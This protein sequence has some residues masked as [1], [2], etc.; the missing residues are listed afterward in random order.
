MPSPAP[1]VPPGFVGELYDY[2]R[3]GVEWLLRLHDNGTSGLLADEMGL[4]KTIQVIA[5]LCHSACRALRAAGGNATAFLASAE[6][7]RVWCSVGCVRGGQGGRVK[8]AGRGSAR[9]PCATPGNVPGWRSRSR[10]RV[11]PVVARNS[12]PALIVAPLAV[13]NN[14]AREFDKFA[15][16]IPVCRYYGTQEER[17]ELRARHIGAGYRDAAGVYHRKP[18]PVFITTYQVCRGGGGRG[19]G[20]SQRVSVFGSVRCPAALADSCARPF[21]RT[22][23]WSCVVV[24]RRSWL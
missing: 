3:K 20:E 12:G 18:L 9:C 13:L 4:G 5:F 15:P 11:V 19:G 23:V 7:M 17:A 22:G 16:H 21:L 1:G 8:Q 14:W 10:S 2:Q 24:C 6:D